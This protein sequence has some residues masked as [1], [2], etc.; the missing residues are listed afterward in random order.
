MKKYMTL[1]C[2]LVLL[3]GLGGCSQEEEPVTKANF[4]L[5]TYVEIKL[6][7]DSDIS[8]I[9]LAFQEIT[10]LEDMLSVNREGSELDQL[11]KAAGKEWVEI[12]PETQEVLL[13]AKEYADLSG[14]LFDVTAGPLIDLWDING[15]GHY[16]TQAELDAVLPLIS[17]DDLLVEDGKAYLAREGMEANL[18]AIAKGYIADKVKELLMDQ[19]VESAIIDLGRNVLLIG[20][21]PDGSNFNVGVQDPNQD[22]GVLLGL[23]STAD[24]SVVTSGIN[25]RY[26]TYEG[27]DYH[28]ILDP[29]TG[30]PADN[31]LASVTIL[32]TNSAQGDALSTTCLLL[33]AEKG[34]ELIESLEGVEAFFI[35]KDGSTTMSSGFEEIYTPY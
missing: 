23:V 6:Y 14:G 26:F 35:T 33:G 16:P 17:S 29:F 3:L 15:E 20:D 11:A 34:M 31:D 24:T 21:K 4:L 7:D 32:S 28:H 27:V 1:F 18:G 22:Q 9:D 12:S 25:E 19:G 5:D 10:R 8:V 30:F 13:L 2:A